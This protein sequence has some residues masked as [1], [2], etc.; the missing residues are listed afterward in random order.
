MQWRRFLR[1]PAAWLGIVGTVLIVYGA[2]AVTEL[3][4][5]AHTGQSFLSTGVHAVADAVTFEVGLGKGAPFLRDVQVEFKS[6]DQQSIQTALSWI[7]ADTAIPRSEERQNPD[8]G[9]GTR[10]H[11]GSST[12]QMTPT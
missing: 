1:Q 3:T 7:D 12:F 4:L 5:R 8:P 6:A 11:S 9:P 2:I 10:P